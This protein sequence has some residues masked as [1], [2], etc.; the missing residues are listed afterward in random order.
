M[1]RPSR[2]TRWQ[3]THADSSNR[4]Y[5]E[6]PHF[7]LAHLVVSDERRDWILKVYPPTD[8]GRPGILVREL[9]KRKRAPA[10]R[11]AVRQSVRPDE[12]VTEESSA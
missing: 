12:Y 4:W 1:G 10:K 6:R 9:D 11:D 7:P 5:R 3:T 8:V 2:A